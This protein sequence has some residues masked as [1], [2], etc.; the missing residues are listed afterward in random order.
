M[1]EKQRCFIALD[2]PKEIIDEL[3]KIQN[4]LNKQNLFIGKFT[5]EE[6]VHLTLKFLGSVQKDTIT[7]IKDR[8]KGVKLASFEASSDELGIF[9][10][11]FIRIIWVKLNGNEVF[12]LQE[13]IDSKLV[14]FFPKEERFMSHITIAR[15]KS[16]KDKQPL[17]DALRKIKLNVKGKI[18]SFSLIESK[19][20]PS[21]PIYEVI[22]TYPLK[23]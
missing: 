19:L 4:E 22:Q 20:M 10:E 7:K 17:Y 18:T 8:L 9:S 14:D 5:E 12:D 16:I 2:L 6:N 15:V 21:G 3:K 23:P 11:E 1:S 13:Q